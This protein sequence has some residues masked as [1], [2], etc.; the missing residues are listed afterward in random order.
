MTQRIA[1]LVCAGLLTEAAPCRADQAA[2]SEVPHAHR[3]SADPDAAPRRENAI[4]GM[5]GLATPVG[6]VGVEGVHRLGSLELTAGVGLGAS[7]A[8]SEPNPPVGHVLQW[9]VMPRFRLAG[10]DHLALLFG[11][12]LSGG[13][14]SSDILSF[15]EE[16]PCYYSTRYVVWLNSELSV[17]QWF[18]HLTLRYFWGIAAGCDATDCTERRHVIPYLGMGIGYAF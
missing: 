3:L 10:D 2:D 9:A 17:E 6:V 14:Y 13:Q 8:N 11:E 18:S 1:A 4:Y 7:A 16:P 15:C 12:G 5:F